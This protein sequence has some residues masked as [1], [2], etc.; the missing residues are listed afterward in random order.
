MY[1][2]DWSTVFDGEIYFIIRDS[3]G[4]EIQRFNNEPEALNR[5]SQLN[6]VKKDN[7]ITMIMK[8]LN[9]CLKNCALLLF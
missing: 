7:V 6:P 4:N 1:S 5:L 2:L 9:K 8:G 3:Q